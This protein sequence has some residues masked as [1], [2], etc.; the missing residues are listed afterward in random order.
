MGVETWRLL[1]C[2]GRAPVLASSRRRLG[3]TICR[4]N[5]RMFLSLVAAPNASL[6]LRVRVRLDVVVPDAFV[7]LSSTTFNIP[8]L[9][10]VSS[11]GA[12]GGGANRPA[13]S[14]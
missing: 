14:S 6:S 5:A 4:A 7:R 1:R 3:S 11:C 10:S 13:R 2:W 12:L 8:L 9:V